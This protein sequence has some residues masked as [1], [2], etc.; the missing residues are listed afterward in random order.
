MDR[1]IRKIIHIFG[2]TPHHYLPMKHFFVGLNV[3]EILQEFWAWSVSG[4]AAP[5]GFTQYMNA[6]ELLHLMKK[7]ADVGSI[8]VFHGMFDRHLWPR[9]A[10]S[11]LPKQCLWVCWGADL[12]EHI[13]ESKTIKRRVA[14]FFH[15]NLVKRFRHVIALNEGDSELI[16]KHLAK[17]KVDV[18]PYPLIASDNTSL[19]KKNDTKLN[20]LVGNSGASSNNHI[21]ALEWLSKFKDENILVSVLLNYGGSSDYVNNVVQHGNTLLGEKFKPIVEMMG[22]DEYDSFLAGIDVAVFA[23]LR[24]QGLYV[25][26][27]M[28]KHGRK[29]YVR[30]ATSTFSEL[31][32]K[33]FYVFPSECIKKQTFADFCAQTPEQRQNNQTLMTMVYSESALRPKWETL[34]KDSVN[35]LNEDA[36]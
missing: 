25:V 1:S 15:R 16:S 24:Q 28:L 14:H 9:L 20:I 36:H 23:H 32:H 22:K 5:Q 34:I 12:Y 7:N 33:G 35:K 8:F 4:E 19:Q 11:G 27:S 10:F 17:R 30:G 6:N 31:E 13:A 2:Q 29:M 26:Y 18:V 21:E 3:E